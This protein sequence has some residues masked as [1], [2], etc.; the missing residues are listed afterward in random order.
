MRISAFDDLDQDIQ[1][2]FCQAIQF[3]HK[4]RLCGGNVLVHWFLIFNFKF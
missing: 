4:A 2:F 3:I 1:Q